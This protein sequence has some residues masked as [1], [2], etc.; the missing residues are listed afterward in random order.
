MMRIGCRI[1]RL[2]IVMVLCLVAEAAVAQVVE[3]V[4]TDRPDQSDGIYTLPKHVFQIE[5]GVTVADATVLNN[6]MVR[7][8]VTPTTEVRVSVDAGKSGGSNGLLPVTASIKQ[9]IV[10]ERAAIPAITFVGYIGSERLA[11][12]SFRG[13]KTPVE[14][15]LAFEN[16]LSERMS[17]AYNVG[18]SDWFRDLILTYGLG[19]SITDN[20]SSFAEYFALFGHGSYAHN[21]DVGLLYTA[22]PD[23]QLD[24]A[25]G[26][27]IFDQE[28]RKFLTVGLSVRLGAR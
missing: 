2:S 5:N 20:L 4:N 25:G 8:G 26:R 19:Y 24:I 18:T 11:T 10:A 27:A 13:D 28:P 17:M 16:T 7:Y 21:V 23:F 9:R 22:S 14:L 3:S 15:K 6:L 1:L 12:G